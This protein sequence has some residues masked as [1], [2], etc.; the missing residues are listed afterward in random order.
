M[1]PTSYFSKGCFLKFHRAH[2]RDKSLSTPSL[3]QESTPFLK[4]SI[5]LLDMRA[6]GGYS[7][8]CMPPAR[9]CSSSTTTTTTSS[10]L[11]PRCYLPPQVTPI[12]LFLLLPASTA[13]T[14]NT[15]SPPQPKPPPHPDPSASASASALCADRLF[16][17]SFFISV[18][19][20]QLQIQ[21]CHIN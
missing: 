21:S 4:G 9:S 13:N 16:L 3:N 7:S 8:R 2:L 15:T 18:P 19:Y 12:L 5:F 11:R 20:C 17:E 14:A 6:H 1:A 10:Q